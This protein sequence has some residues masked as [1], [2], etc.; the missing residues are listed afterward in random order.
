MHTDQYLQWDSHH[1]LIAKYSVVS[2]LTHRK[3]VVCTRPDL[4]TKDLQHLRTALTKYMYLKRALDKFKGKI[5]NN[6]EDSNTQGE[7]LEEDTSNPSGNT[8]WRDPNKD[9]HNKCHIVILY[10][11]GL[12]GGH[13]EGLQQIWYPDSF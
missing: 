4:L 11:Q 6:W 3:K 7:N 2:S 13:Q 10:I 8:T 9:K 1:N 12:G 5:I